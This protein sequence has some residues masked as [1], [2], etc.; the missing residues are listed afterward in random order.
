MSSISSGPTAGRPDN[1]LRSLQSAV[2]PELDPESMRADLNSL[3]GRVGF[4]RTSTGG[5]VVKDTTQVTGTQRTASSSGAPALYGSGPSQLLPP[6]PPSITINQNLKQG[7]ES[8]AGN[9]DRAM[10]GFLLGSSSNRLTLGEGVD[11]GGVVDV[12]TLSID[13][14]SA[15]QLLTEFLK[16]NI[17][18]P[19]NSVEVHNALQQTASDLRIAA[20]EDAKKQAEEAARLQAKA[21]KYAK[22]AG[23]IGKIVQV[24]MIV[25]TVLTAGAA[26]P[27][28]LAAM[29][30]G[31]AASVATGGNILDGAA[32]AATLVTVAMG[33]GALIQAAKELGK[34]AATE[35]VKGA[36]KEVVKEAVTEAG[37]EAG[38]GFS[39][40]ALAA[41]NAGGQATMAVANNQ[42]AQRS[43]D[44]Q[45][46]SLDA[47][48]SRKRAERAQQQIE[49]EGEIIKLIL[50][51]K[52][53]TVE[54]VLRL[55]N[56]TFVTNTKLQEISK[57]A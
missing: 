16:L 56:A 30:I 54:A 52:N 1:E 41:V 24:I 20:L 17:N 43:L 57:P 10:N 28:V 26:L 49:D 32:M 9:I 5:L 44:A 47:E 15:D 4:E 2:L 21:A 31:A 50:D 35:A 33:I 37:K 12:G 27:F 3:L 40:A 14:L 11:T 55:M 29:A 45:Q 8:F 53:Q 39:K 36:A 51:S 19:N 25:A 22:L 6:S 34:K 23:V 13:Q 48:E 18:D 38:K 42:A 7:A 46:S